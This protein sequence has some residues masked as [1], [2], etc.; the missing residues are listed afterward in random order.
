MKVL[1][2]EAMG[3]G[4]E[5]EGAFPGDEVVVSDG[6]L[7]ED[8][9]IREGEGAAVLSVFIRTKVS[10][11]VIDSLPGLR[12]INTR[13]AGFDHIAAAHALE[14][15]IVV[16]HVPDY[17]PHAVAE[18]AFCL[19]LACAR[20]L[21]PADRSVR[22][23]RRFDFL[24]FRG[25]ELKDKVLGVVG[26]GRIGAE[27]IRIAQGFGMR[28]I[29]FDIYRN[30]TLAR[31]YGFSYLSL[32]EVLE[33]SDF[34]TIHLPLTPD[35]ENLI[36]RAALA[37][38]KRGAILINTA[39]GRIV[40]ERALRE[41]LDDGRLA[42]A[43]VDVIEDEAHIEKDPLVGSDK[44]II[45]PHIAFYTEESMSRMVAESIRTIREFRSGKVVNEV[46]EEY[47]KR[48]VVRTYPQD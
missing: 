26:T 24:P 9:I 11:K 32:E 31:R 7:G 5:F 27:M 2:T 48:T 38:M 33:G 17:G 14:K 15:G 6:P 1:F 44:A 36:D 28:V 34:V 37:R 23:D 29:A 35:T 25:L 39:R 16:T 22:Q 18:H 30:E 3:H 40:D 12:M 10:D 45:T 43:G 4:E 19:L 13:S 47:V 46:P 42:G 41:A 20:K 8:E 21:V